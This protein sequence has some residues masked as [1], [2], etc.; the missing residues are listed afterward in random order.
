M[1]WGEPIAVYDSGLVS[2]TINR[3]KNHLF[4]EGYFHNNVTANVSTFGKFVRV[5][6]ELD[7]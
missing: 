1:Q 7:G 2:I 4:S 5:N 3:F 6:Y